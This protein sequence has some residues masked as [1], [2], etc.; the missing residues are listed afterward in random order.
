MEQGGLVISRHG[1]PSVRPKLGGTPL[2]A[3]A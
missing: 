1:V 3:R 2:I